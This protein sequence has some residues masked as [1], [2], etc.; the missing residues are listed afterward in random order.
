MNTW[1]HQFL[2][3]P[4]EQ[5]PSLEIQFRLHDTILYQT[6]LEY[7]QSF[8]IGRSAQND[9]ALETPLLPMDHFTLV[10]FHAKG[11]LIQ[12]TSTMRG[13]LQRGKTWQCL[14][15]L[16]HTHKIHPTPQGYRLQLP[17]GA[18]LFLHLDQLQI[19]ARWSHQPRHWDSSAP[20]Q[21]RWNLNR[22]ED[23]PLGFARILPSSPPP[24]SPSPHTHFHHPL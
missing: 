20:F 6:S 5:G 23:I 10:Q 17:L 3:I 14:D 22:S 9:F 18:A 2:G 13:F 7:G 15:E 19:C 1:L 8:S 24:T 11:A 4:A 12:F 16:K 21:R